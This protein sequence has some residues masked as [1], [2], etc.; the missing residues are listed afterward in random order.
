ML[1]KKV[2][3][4]LLLFVFNLGVYGFFILVTVCISSQRMLVEALP[5]LS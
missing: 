5:T 1:V 3:F 2:I 4:V